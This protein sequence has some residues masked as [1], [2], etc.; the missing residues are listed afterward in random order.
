MIQILTFGVRNFMD[1]K[2]LKITDCLTFVH[3][4]HLLQLCSTSFLEIKNS[5]QNLKTFFLYKKTRQKEKKTR[6][7]KKKLSTRKKTGKRD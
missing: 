6:Q 4:L 1:I 3:K 5:K 2:L 7:N